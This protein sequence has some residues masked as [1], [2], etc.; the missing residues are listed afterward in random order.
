M[1]L[2]KLTVLRPFEAKVAE[3]SK[4]SIST[5]LFEAAGEFA[6]RLS[7]EPAKTLKDASFGELP[8]SCGAGL[9]RGIH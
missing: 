3:K 2:S 5:S 4:Q 7:A 1:L 8:C 9:S 6:R